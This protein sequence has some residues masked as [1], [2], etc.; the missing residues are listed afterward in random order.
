MNYQDYKILIDN[1]NKGSKNAKV[2][3][4]ATKGGDKAKS[5]ME[6]VIK[7]MFSDY[8]TEFKFL[9]NRKFKFDFYIPSAR[10]GIEY[11]GMFSAK[12]RHLTVT[13]FSKDCE[14]TNLAQLN[15]YKVLRYTQLTYSDLQ[16]DLEL[17][18]SKL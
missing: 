14:K 8:V 15:G 11:D 4:P 12:S 1:L 7:S 9:D 17:L 13:G 5:Q 2:S 18:K 3:V 6:F 16:K 10:T